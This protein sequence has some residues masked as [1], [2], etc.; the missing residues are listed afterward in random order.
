MAR[1][2][3]AYRSMNII[4]LQVKKSESVTRLLGPGLWFASLGELLGAL[5]RGG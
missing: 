3:L 2:S 1:E 4:Y 5:A